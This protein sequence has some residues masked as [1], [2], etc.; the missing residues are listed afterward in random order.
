MP[1]YPITEQLKSSFIPTSN[2][3]VGT[4]ASANHNYQLINNNPLRRFL[5]FQNTH[6]TAI[7]YLNFGAAA[8]SGSALQGMQIQPGQMLILD[9]AVPYSSVQVASGTIGATYYILEG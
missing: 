2:A 8:W 1:Q 4:L 3:G 5:I 9:V 6:S 7:I